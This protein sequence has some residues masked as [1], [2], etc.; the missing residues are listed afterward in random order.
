MAIALGTTPEEEH[1]PGLAPLAR[2]RHNFTIYHTVKAHFSIVQQIKGQV[3]LLFVDTESQEVTE[4]FKDIHQPDFTQS[5]Y[6]ASR[7][8]ILPVGS[9]MQHHSN[10]P[11]PFPLSEELQLREL[12]LTTVRRKGCADF[13]ESARLC[14]QARCSRRSRLSCSS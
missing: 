3:G 1:G 5:G 6:R 14:G 7:T 13:G 9:I 4:R 12:G 11:E 10:P 8:V 2:V